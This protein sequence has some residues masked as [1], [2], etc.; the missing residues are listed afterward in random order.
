MTKS[1][2]R[3][4]INPHYYLLF[5]QEFQHNDDRNKSLKSRTPR[6]S[7]AEAPVGKQSSRWKDLHSEKS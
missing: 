3:N 4:Y 2:E 7:T 5:N 6:L 1:L